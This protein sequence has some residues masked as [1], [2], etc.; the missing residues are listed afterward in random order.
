MEYLNKNT[1]MDRRKF[2]KYTVHPCLYR[3]EELNKHSCRNDVY[4][5][6]IGKVFFE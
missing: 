4:Y 6:Y 3:I 5:K 2:L 1:G